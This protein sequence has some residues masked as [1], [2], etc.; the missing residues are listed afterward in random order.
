MCVPQARFMCRYT[1]NLSRIK[2]NTHLAF[3]Q[4]TRRPSPYGQRDQ[5]IESGSWLANADYD[6]TAQPRSSA[7]WCPERS[8]SFLSTAA[9]RCHL[10]TANRMLI[11][12]MLQKCFLNFRFFSHDQFHIQIFTSLGKTG[13]ANSQSSRPFMILLCTWIEGQYSNSLIN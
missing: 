12:I 5:H 7:A 1:S 3:H 9:S 13:T 2:D 10:E 6:P 8:P 11:E 4:C